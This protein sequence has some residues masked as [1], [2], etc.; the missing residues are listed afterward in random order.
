MILL[1]FTFK[2]V[3]SIPYSDWQTLYQVRDVL[4]VSTA[5]SDPRFPKGVPD[6]KV[7]I[8]PCWFCYFPTHVSS[9]PTDVQSTSIH[10]LCYV[11]AQS[12]R[13]K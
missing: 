2:I 5:T 3:L 12:Y 9:T 11:K 13:Y 1:Y 8:L 4:R 7:K 10:D 6:L